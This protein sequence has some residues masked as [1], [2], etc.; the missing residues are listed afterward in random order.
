MRGRPGYEAKENS[1]Q[2]VKK[3]S[4]PRIKLTDKKCELE[5]ALEWH[6][7][8]VVTTWVQGTVNPDQS[9]VYQ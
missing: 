9:N 8:N 5:Y 6:P 7:S 4:H 2:S 3:I 1:Q